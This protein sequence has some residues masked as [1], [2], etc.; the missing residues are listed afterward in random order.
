MSNH[1]HVIEVDEELS[2]DGLFGATITT[3][4]G[5]KVEIWAEVELKGKCAVVRQPSIDGVNVSTNALGVAELR[6]IVKALM[7][8]FD[9]DCVRIEE[10]RR[11]S[12]AFPGRTV[13]PIR[14][15]R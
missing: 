13:R 15:R 6:G 14:I 9:V 11:T 4:S 1:D 5:K 2:Q 3:P 7:E 12:G 10:A 8:E